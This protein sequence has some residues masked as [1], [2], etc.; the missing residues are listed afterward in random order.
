MRI[1]ELIETTCEGCPYASND[2]DLDERKKPSA[3]RCHRGKLGA[4]DLSSCIAQ[5]FTKH[6]TNTDHTAGTGKQGKKGSGKPVKNRK[7]ASVVHGGPVKDY[8]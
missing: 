5:G 3:S 1:N 6:S 4:S 8:S 7:I 2:Q